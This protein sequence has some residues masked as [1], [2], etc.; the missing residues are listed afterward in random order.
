MFL[1]DIQTSRGSCPWGLEKEV[2][3]TE[4]GAVRRQPEAVRS[5]LGDPCPLACHLIPVHFAV[6]IPAQV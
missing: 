2:D 4:V 5:T 1:I 3:H 6:G